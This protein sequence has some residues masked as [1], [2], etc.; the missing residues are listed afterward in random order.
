M[1]GRSLG[2]GRRWLSEDERRAE[3]ESRLYSAEAQLWELSLTGEPLDPLLPPAL[4]HAAITGGRQQFL[5]KGSGSDRVARRDVSYLHDEKP[6]R[7]TRP[8]LSPRRQPRPNSAKVP[9]LLAAVAAGSSKHRGGDGGGDGGGDS[10]RS[11][12]RRGRCRRAQRPAGCTRL[13]RAE[14][15]GRRRAYPPR[16]AG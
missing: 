5:Q 8:S 14:R 13:H 16:R 15:R 3:L 4:L 2:A 9:A 10:G 6:P 1:A 12:R 11:A 7:P